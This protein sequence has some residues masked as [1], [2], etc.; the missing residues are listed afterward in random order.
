MHQQT[1]STSPINLTTR[2]IH[3]W[4]RFFHAG[5]VILVPALLA[6]ITLLFQT[7]QRRR[8]DEQKDQERR[9]EAWKAILETIV[10]SIKEHYVPLSRKMATVLGRIESGNLEETTRAM[11]VMRRQM[12]LLVEKNG[13]FYFRIKP[14]ETLCRELSNLLWAN[15]Y[16]AAGMD[17]ILPLVAVLDLSD[18]LPAAHAKLTAQ[19]QQEY[20]DL[21]RKIGAQ[22]DPAV[23]SLGDQV[24]IAKTA[25]L[26]TRMI[27]ILD[28]ESDRV[29]YPEWYEDAPKIETELFTRE[30][31]DASPLT[32]Q[33]KA[34]LETAAQ[35]Y[36]ATISSEFLTPAAR[37]PLRRFAFRVGQKLVELGSG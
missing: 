14:A 24:F 18:N 6:F 34:D 10:T 17:T 9:L 13:G 20:T 27:S 19:K 36:L 23:A 15:W 16:G 8:D 29:L 33:E 1:V 25:M 5:G 31:F 12:E 30:A 28:F 4:E 32:A 7:G 22:M 2:R 26:L 3:N 37:N 11:L 21:V 35:D